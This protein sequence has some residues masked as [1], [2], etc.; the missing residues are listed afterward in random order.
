M[1]RLL[2]DRMSCRAESLT[3]KNNKIRSIVKTESPE[4]MSRPLLNKVVKF[5]L[6]GLV[7]CLHSALVNA[8][9]L[10]HVRPAIP[11]IEIVTLD[12][13]PYEYEEDGVIK[14]IAVDLVEEAF[15][16]LNQP[17]NIR[18]VP[19]ARALAL[20]E[21]GKADAIFTAYKTPERELFCDYSNEVLIDQT[22]SLFVRSDSTIEFDGNLSLMEGYTF[23]TVR[24]ISYGSVFDQAV[25][26]GMISHIEETRS[27]EKNMAMLILNRVDILVSNKY[28]A[29]DILN[30]LG[31]EDDVRELDPEV[32]TVPSYLAFSKKRGLGHIRDQFDFTLKEMKMDG[33]YQKII[34]AHFDH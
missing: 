3:H 4:R 6:A 21:E 19:W 33:T 25:E 15:D 12:Y 29:Y 16:R 34:D 11:P 20:V 10:L 26:Q 7:V 31:R 18:M 22:V 23:G 14:G 8:D 9:E 1:P 2:I 28:G 27:G 30:K 5:L 13:P 24:K 32:Q 17:I